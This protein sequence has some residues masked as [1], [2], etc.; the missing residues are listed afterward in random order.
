MNMLAPEKPEDDKTRTW[1]PPSLSA[2]CHK[3]GTSAWG[4]AKRRYILVPAA[5]LGFVVLAYMYRN[6]YQP[7]AVLFGTYKDLIAFTVICLVAGRLVLRK[8]S[9]AAKNAGTVLA[10]AFALGL[11]WIG[12][13]AHRYI[14]QWARY[15]TLDYVE[16]A[17]MPMTD[18][19]RVLSLNGVHTLAARFRDQTEKVAT[20]SFVRTSKGYCWSIAV[21][22]DRW[23]QRFNNP[24]DEILCLPGSA[25]NPDFSRRGLIRVNFEIGENLLFS[26][27]TDNCVRRSLGPWRFFN[28]EP[29]RVVYIERVPGDWIQ[30]VPWIKWVGTLGVLFP[31]PEF[32]GVQVIEQS[33]VYPW[34]RRWFWEAPKRVFTGCGTWIRPQEV[35]KHAYLRGQ[36]LMPDQVSRSMAE[37]FRFQEGFVDPWEIFKV[38]DIRIADLQG[39][40]NKQP[41]TSFYRMPQAPAGGDKLYDSFALEP[42]DLSKQTLVTSYFVAGDGMGKSYVYRHSR[43]NEAPLGV[44]AVPN[45]L[46]ESRPDVFW[47]DRRP[48]ESRYFIRD[49]PDINGVVKRRIMYITTVVLVDK[50]I[51]GNKRPSYTTGAAPLIAIT[52]S[53]TRQVAWVDPIHPEKWDAEVQAKF[54]A[55]WAR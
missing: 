12:G 10:V 3:I 32:G 51:D 28:Y 25:A 5:T 19:E 52:D 23:W 1:E 29:G 15:K 55:Q 24:V 42:V 18:N 16:L 50:A 49:L 4:L 27:N 35:G 53:Q 7:Y 17:Q 20:P 36:N 22:P 54:G 21:Q 13:D 31:R 30:I 6:L 8:R 33:P 45:I 38:G 44:T 39:D 2:F 37:S 14:G 41:F 47:T 34:Y 11:V 40:V 9:V 48:D 46:R 43:R 26:R